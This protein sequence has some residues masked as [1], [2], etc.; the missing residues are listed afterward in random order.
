LS[1]FGGCAMRL[2][3]ALCLAEA[4]ALRLASPPTRCRPAMARMED[5]PETLAE[6]ARQEV[7]ASALPGTYVKPYSMALGVSSA[8]VLCNELVPRIASPAAAG[9]PLWLGRAAPCTGLPLLVAAF[10]VLRKAARVGPAELLGPDCQR[11]NLALALT[12]IV[13]VVSSPRPDLSVTIAR[14]GSALLCLEVWSQA[15]GCAGNMFGEVSALVRGAIS[16]C[17][18]C[19]QLAL[20]TA[21]PLAAR[22]YAL[23]SLCYGALAAAF[24]LSP[25]R[26][27]SA[28]WPVVTPAATSSDMAR[29]IAVAGLAAVSCFTLGDGR[30]STGTLAG[31]GQEGGELDAA[32]LPGVSSRPLNLGLTVATA[33]HLAVQTISFFV[34]PRAPLSSAAIAVQLLHAVTFAFGASQA[35][36]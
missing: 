23:L 2:V 20:G 16:S 12:S 21:V 7:P 34:Q 25:A 18:R 26:A 30:C 27:T 14:A 3:L 9:L 36:T 1:A 32:E 29:G 15:T 5:T 13:A 11:L 22:A 31:S 8:A 4:R 6:T 33:C 24:A 19:V 17:V 10:I 35:R 28:F